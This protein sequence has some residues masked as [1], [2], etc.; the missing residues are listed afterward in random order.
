M[1]PLFAVEGVDQDEVITG[2]RGTL[3]QNIESCVRQVESDVEAGVRNFLLFAVPEHKDTKDFKYDFAVET[4]FKLKKEFGPHIQLWVDTCLCSNTEHGHC[5][6]FRADGVA[7]HE[8]TLSEISRAALTYVQAGA[9]GISPSDMMD[10]RVAAIRSTLDENGNDL[11]P[12][13]SYSTKF[14][15]VLYGPFRNAANSAPQFGDRRQYQIDVRN[16]TDAIGS[17]VRCAEEGADLLMLKPGQP[18]IDLISDIRKETGL[19]VGV[20]QVSGEYAGLSLMAKE[21][22]LDFNAAL[23]ESWHVFR[24][25]GAQYIITYGARYGRSMG[26]TSGNY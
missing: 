22:L 10:G 24:R 20:Y 6:L 18:S 21:G 13:M 8:A 7:D 25:A 5:C 19:P 9:N 16:R 17:S 4:I 26:F 1:Q 15:S 14:A 2:L 11:I 3:R 12:I 23:L